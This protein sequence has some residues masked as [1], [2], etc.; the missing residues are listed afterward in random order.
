[1]GC[2]ITGAG[3]GLVYIVGANMEQLHGRIGL[4]YWSGVKGVLHRRKLYNKDDKR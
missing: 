3:D 1:M 4:S 2:S